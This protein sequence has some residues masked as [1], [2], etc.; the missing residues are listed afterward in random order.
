MDWN[1]ICRPK[2]LDD[3]L[4][5]KQEIQKAIQWIQNY[6][7][8]IP[9]TK[10]VLLILGPTGV[11][12]TLL[13]DILFNEYNYQK[14]ELN[15]SDIRTQKK[16]GEFLKKA[17][18]FKNVVDMFHDGNLPI[19]IL[20]DEI[21]TICKLN[22]KGGMNEFIDILKV[23]DKYETNKKKNKKSTKINLQDYIKLYNPIICTSN[24]INDKKINEL[25]KYSEVIKL[26]KP[27]NEDIIL[28]I[29]NIYNKNNILYNENVL[30]NIADFCL[31]DIR[32][33][34]QTCYDLYTLSNENIID[35]S[36]FNSFNKTYKPK[37][38]DLQLIE[39]TKLLFTEKLE[40]SRSQIL[41]DIDCL[42]TPLMIYHNSI[43][44]I[45]NC[46]DNSKK[47]INIFKNILHSLCIHD[48]IQTSI[49]EVQDWDELYHLAAFFGSSLPNCLL[50]NLKN[51]KDVQIEFTSL[52]NKISQMYVNKKLLNSA[53][54]SIKSLNYDNDELIYLS[55]IMSY[56]FDN[57]KKTDNTN[58][59]SDDDSDID[60]DND[61][62]HINKNNEDIFLST[63][64][65]Q[66]KETNN[67]ELITFMNKYKMNIDD[68]ENILKIEKLNKTT[69]KRKKKFTLKIKKE[70]TNHLFY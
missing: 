41:F 40:I 52:L 36:I 53:K 26:N 60:I 62:E 28:I 29:K 20:M 42:L 56:Y 49:F 5:N 67:S 7:N 8:N 27:S 54:F 22:D 15:S 35:N 24:D 21:D 12:K 2:K 32:Q 57:Y 9:D 45:K 30:N 11:G 16:L 51:K 48:T 69:E 3:F 14:I 66:H 18:S 46:E 4:I 31:G 47:K 58:N 68:L 25:K 23:N 39:S 10:R 70:I 17:L 55:E 64:P 43:P 63:L 44:F 6:K 59:L 38:E 50:T 33:L 1:D 34:I 19:G 65:K 37:T 61:N 13:A